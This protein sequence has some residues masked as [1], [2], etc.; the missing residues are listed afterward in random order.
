MLL[1]DH[2]QYLQSYEAESSMQMEISFKIM[3]V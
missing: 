1:F 3:A 2:K